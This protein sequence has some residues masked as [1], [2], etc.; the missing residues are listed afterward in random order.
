MDLDWTVSPGEPYLQTWPDGF[1]VPDLKH[2]F[3]KILLHFHRH[4]SLNL[5]ISENSQSV[6]E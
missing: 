3:H 6:V 4:F 1:S 2:F 5:K